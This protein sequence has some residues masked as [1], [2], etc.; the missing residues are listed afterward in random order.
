[1]D[2]AKKFRLLAD[3]HR[4]SHFEWRRTAMGLAPDKEPLEIT[5]R[6]W[7]H[8]GRDTAKYY[9]KQIDREKSLAAEMA[10]LFVS[11]SVAMG[12][13]AEVLEDSSD[14]C[15]QAR[16]NDCPWFHWHK[17]EGLLTEDQAGC[18]HWLETVIEEINAALGTQLAFETVQSLPA[19]GCC[20]HRKFWEEKA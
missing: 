19:G 18:D 3:I 8:V 16:H 20:C 11:S 10:R 2:D 5:K 9:L 6:Y 13:D 7:T 12:E 1:M 15:A 17:R 14:G 4:A